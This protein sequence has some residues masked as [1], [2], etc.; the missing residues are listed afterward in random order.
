MQIKNESMTF[1]K[2]ISSYKIRIPKYQRDYVQG[3]YGRVCKKL[4]ND[5]KISI[6]DNKKIDLGFVYGSVKN[7]YFEPIDGQ[8]RLT[9]L[10][11][12]YVYFFVLTKDFTNLDILINNFDYQT[13]ITSSRFFKS[14]AG[15]INYNVGCSISEFVKNAE[16]Y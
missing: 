8:Q 13:R 9:T 15:M 4:L 12:I 10:F 5:I 3:N 16:W 1:W 2:L 14:L 7:D 11:L 6:I